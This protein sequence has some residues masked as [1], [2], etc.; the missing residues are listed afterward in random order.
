MKNFIILFIYLFTSIAWADFTT[1]KRIVAADVI[2]GTKSFENYIKDSPPKAAN[3]KGWKCYADAAGVLPVD[4]T[5]G[6]PTVTF[7]SSATTPL[8]NSGGGFIFTHL[9][10]NQQG[11][12][13]S[14]DFVIDPQDKAKMLDV[15][16]EYIVRSGTF[17]AGGASTDS[18]VEIFVYDITNAAIVGS[19]S[20][21]KLLSNST[22]LSDLFQA[23][24]QSASN[25]TSYRL[26]LHSS[27]TVATAFTIGFGDISVARS[28][29]T[30]GTPITDPVLYTPTLTT[31][32]GTT[33]NNGFNWSRQGKYLFLQ[34]TFTSGTVTASTAA[35]SLPAG[36]TID[37]TFLSSSFFS[38][39]GQ[40]SG[41]GAGGPFWVLAKGG[42]STVSFSFGTNAIAAQ[43][44]NAMFSS[45]QNITFWAKV[46]IVGWSSSVQMSDQ[47]DL[48]ILA[49]SYAVGIGASTTLN[50]PI[51]FDTKLSDPSGLITVGVG[52]WK[53]IAQ[54]PGTY[55]ISGSIA[56]GGAPNIRIWKNGSAYA[57]LTSI[58]AGGPISPFATEIF[59]NIGDYID[60]RP[61][62]TVTPTGGSLGTYQSTISFSKIAGPSTIAVTESVNFKYSTTAGQSIAS[63]SGSQVV[64]GTKDWDTHGMMNTSTGTWT[65]PI[66]GKYKVC[67]GVDYVSAGIT[68]G[69]QRNVQFYKN[70]SPINYVINYPLATVTQAIAAFGCNLYNVIAGDTGAIYT[71]ANEGTARSLST[72][73]FSNYITLERVGN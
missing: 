72:S 5:G 48:K 51:N 60:L 9:A 32:F 38:V 65:F 1:T 64:W 68:A 16:L 25:S 26:I 70:G 23:T 55:R 52:S 58:M 57:Y 40:T 37:S 10:S 7:T 30:F 3:T 47:A 6:S 50:T 41:T 59:L 61:D 28:R 49:A 15:N 24:F 73:G 62:S 33:T 69:N 35:I 54:T 42:D 13:C 19:L 4:G 66:Q 56:T 34:A 46:P 67:A 43:A 71:N 8:K 27:T 18:D 53:A 21:N 20:S 12:G 45:S 22:T 29:Y 36:L 31:G 14:Y 63:P 2:Q 39:V 11:M 44:A 17:T